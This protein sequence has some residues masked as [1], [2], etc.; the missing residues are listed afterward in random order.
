MILRKAKTAYEFSE[1]KEK[2]NHLLFMDDLKLCSRIEKVLDSLVQTVGVFSEDIRMEF[3]IEKCAKLA[4]ERE[5]IVK[6]VDIELPDGK[7][8]TWLQEGES[9]KYL[10][11]LE[12][13]KHLEEKVK[14]N[15][16]KEYIRR[17]RSFE[18]K[19]EWWEFG[20]WS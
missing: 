19:T 12:A 13:D 6:S 8:I 18:V 15:V 10:E 20:L 1:S 3:D 17:L 9:Y 16:L 11:I 4:M 14:L 2:I 5:K 7:V